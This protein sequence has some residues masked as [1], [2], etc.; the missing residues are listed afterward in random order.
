[1]PAC[2]NRLLVLAL[3]GACTLA[4]CATPPMSGSITPVDVIAAPDAFRGQVRITG[5]LAFGSLARQLWTDGRS[6]DAQTAC[7]T[8]VNT[9]P[10]R[11]TLT[12]LDG[13]RITVTG[14]IVPDTWTAADGSDV[15]DLG[16]C[17][18]I[19]LL[20]RGVEPERFLPTRER[21]SWRN[22][23][24]KHLVLV[25]PARHDRDF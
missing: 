18:R 10:F 22:H 23:K 5:R 9:Y 15:V 24:L 6:D 14:A 2:S 21:L 17:N 4:S 13:R 1:M 19:G 25:P 7:I 11:D 20:V 8:L 12:R 3:I 16:S